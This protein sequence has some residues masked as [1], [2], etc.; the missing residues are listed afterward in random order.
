MHRMPHC[1][2]ESAMQ[3]RVSHRLLD[4]S[5][6]AFVA[7]AM[8]LG[9]TAAQAGTACNIPNTPCYPWRIAA[10]REQTTILN[11]IPNNAVTGAIYR[12]CLC[13]PEKAVEIVFSFSGADIVI[14]RASIGNDGPVCRDYRIETS[15]QSRL[16]LRRPPDT[17]GKAIEGCYVTAPLSP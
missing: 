1:A 5:G 4:W 6:A 14:G 11:V 3:V 13:P 16:I 2:I 15:R 8:W 7:C 10:D 12:I 17:L 9:A